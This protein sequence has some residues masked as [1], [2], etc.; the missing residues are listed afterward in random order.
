MGTVL[1]LRDVIQYLVLIVADGLILAFWWLV[2]SRLG[3]R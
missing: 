2:M 3:D 1:P